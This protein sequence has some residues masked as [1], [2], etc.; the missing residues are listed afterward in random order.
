MVASSASRFKVHMYIFLFS[1]IWSQIP[2]N[3]WRNIFRIDYLNCL[4]DFHR[5]VVSEFLLPVMVVVMLQ[6][7]FGVPPKNVKMGVIFPNEISSISEYCNNSQTG[8]GC[9]ENTGICNF[10]DKFNNSEFTWV[11]T[12]YLHLVHLIYMK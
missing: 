2:P 10:L 7:I 8:S 3:K 4:I 11:H 5:L 1:L 12:Y 6:N 9:L